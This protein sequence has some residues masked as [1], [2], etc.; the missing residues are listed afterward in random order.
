V[1]GTGNVGRRFE[2]NAVASGQTIYL[3]LLLHE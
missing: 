1:D 3:P 2:G